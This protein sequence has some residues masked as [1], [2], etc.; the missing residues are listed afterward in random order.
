MNTPQIPHVVHVIDEMPAEGAQR[1]IVEV[2]RNGSS[3]FR[4]SVLC[5]VREG[6]LA[7]ELRRSGVAVHCLQRRPG[8]DP[9]TI[10]A[11]LAWM[12]RERPDVI[13]THLYN[14]DCYARLAAWLAR[15]PGRFSTR[16]SSRPWPTPM[17]RRI[18]RWIGRLSHTT[19]ACGADVQ[20]MLVTEDGLDAT[21][22]RSIA[23]GIDLGRF[24]R[25]D[26][27]KLRREL[28]LAEDEVLIGVVG[29]LI[30]L[31]G[32]QQLIDALAQL[33]RQGLT[34]WQAVF[35]G[36]GEL[37]ETLQGAIATAGLQ[38]RIHL[39]GVRSDMADVLAA[40]DVYA[41]PSHHE[42]LPM[43]LLEAMAASRAVVASAVGSIP[44]VIRDGVSGLLVPPQDV[45]ALAQALLRPMTDPD[46]RQSLGREARQTVLD[47]FSAQR[48]AQAYE[49]L[50]DEVLGHRH[51]T[52]Q[53]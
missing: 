34:R 31:K 7:D 9:G 45:P 23:N 32:H 39:L 11:L 50:Y 6:L 15:V 22:V 21:Q 29:R 5:M 4:Y 30:P 42:G 36:G 51:A 17:R 47:R 3:R 38:G 28:G 19:V 53:S 52:P 46:L 24:D 40:L 44:E 35:V 41:M 8:V 27:G 12:R 1:L 25:A 43:A 2:V 16:H 18:A 14:A 10:P 26:R 49:A 13:H 37:H 20:R 33:Q 48:T